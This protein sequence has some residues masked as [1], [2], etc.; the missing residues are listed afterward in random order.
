MI[1]SDE[2]LRVDIMFA[3]RGRIMP[4]YWKESVNGAAVPSF[5]RNC[6]V[7]RLVRHLRQERYVLCEYF[8]VR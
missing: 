7:Q 1:L 2:L 8:K 4:F 3:E 5:E 6:G